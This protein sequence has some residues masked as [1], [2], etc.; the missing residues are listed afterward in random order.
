MNPFESGARKV[1][2]AVLI[3]ARCEGQL[4]M[5]HRSARG[6]T[7]YHNNKWN[8]VGGKLELDESAPQAARREFYEEAGIELSMERFHCL[9]TLHFPGFKAHKSEDWMVWVFS[10]ELSL[11]EQQKVSA[12][13]SEGSLHWVPFNQVMTKTLWAGDIHFLPQ[14]LKNSLFHGTIWYHGNEVKQFTFAQRAN[15]CDVPEVSW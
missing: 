15:D 12:Q 1:I 7:D 5:I 8:G 13:N 10:I 9:G 3:Y 4:L 11:D 14:V 6:A 2:P